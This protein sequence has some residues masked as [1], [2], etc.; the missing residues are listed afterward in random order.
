MGAVGPGIETG[1][2]ALRQILRAMGR[3]DLIGPRPDQLVPAS[4][5]PGTGA[6]KGQGQPRPMR[7][8]GAP[9]FTTRGIPMRK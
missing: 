4:Q 3:A 6:S 2:L 9:R 8:P 5:P 7:H 1:E